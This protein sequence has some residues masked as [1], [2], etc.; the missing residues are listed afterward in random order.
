MPLKCE[1]EIN[2]LQSENMR[3]KME[4]KWIIEAIAKAQRVRKVHKPLIIHTDV[5]EM[6]SVNL[7]VQRQMEMDLQE[8]NDKIHIFLQDLCLHDII[9]ILPVMSL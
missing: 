7:V 6:M 4:A 8:N 1:Y 3:I 9:Q 2:Q 5:R